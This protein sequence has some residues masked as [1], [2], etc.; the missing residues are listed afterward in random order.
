MILPINQ[1]ILNRVYD[2]SQYTDETLRCKFF[3]KLEECIDFCND[4]G[5]IVNWLKTEGLENEVKTE[6]QIWLDDGTLEDLI[7]LSKLDNMKSELLAQINALSQSTSSSI[8]QLTQTVSDNK[9]SLENKLT[10]E[11]TKFDTDLQS[12]KEAQAK[13]IGDFKTEVN[14]KFTTKSE[15]INTT[16]SNFKN[17]VNQKLSKIFY[18]SNESELDNALMIARSNPTKIYVCNS[19][20]ITSIKF[21]PNNTE[22]IGLGY[23][24]ITASGL[25]CYFANY[26][27]NNPL[28]YNGTKNIKI[29][30]IIFDGLDKADGLTL[31]AIGHAE[32]VQVIECEFKNLHM[33]HMV[34]FNGVK[35]GI[36]RKCKFTNYGNVGSNGTEAIQLDS[37][38]ST[39]QFPWFGSYDGASNQNISI[40][41]CTFENIGAKAI[42]NHSF[43][44]GSVQRDIF[45]KNNYFSKVNTCMT[46]HDFSNL[47][48]DSNVA[49][50]CHGFLSSTNQ[51]NS[52]EKLVMVN[53]NYQGFYISSGEG[54]GDERFLALN[55]TGQVADYKFNDVIICNNDISLIPGHAIGL[56]ADYLVITD[57]NFNRVYRNGIYHFGGYTGTIANNTFRDVGM[58]GGTRRAILING[59]GKKSER[60][61]VNG[62]TIA[63]LG[64]IE[65]S[66]SVGKI[67]VCNNIGSVTN[68]ASDE[69]TVSNNIN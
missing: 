17:E 40:E 63:N 38:I 32:N 57:N 64:G 52:S 14:N 19:I 22:I 42:G 15:E 66:G 35:D 46:I 65:V 68:S 1:S 34:E 31:L 43:Q 54:L 44:T 49:K 33:W 7:N 20:D 41:Y 10:N 58:E 2:F 27:V 60:V 62:N 24:T 4:V 11:L 16:I 51:K 39:S 29:Q 28:A 13:T 30:G 59:G 56:I 21:L 18:V 23:P 67:S 55:P 26:T 8:S 53:N 37:M 61:V 48:I 3:Q 6:L 36:I 12:F 25:N 50:D 45:I 5:D 47:V 9:T 69:C